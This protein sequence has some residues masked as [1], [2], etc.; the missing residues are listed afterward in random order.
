MIELVFFVIHLFYIRLCAQL[1]AKRV[2]G[3]FDSAIWGIV[4][5]YLGIFFCDGVK[6][7]RS[8][9]GK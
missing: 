1:G 8:P 2:I 4:F 7:V 3:G 6:E 9:C 5:S